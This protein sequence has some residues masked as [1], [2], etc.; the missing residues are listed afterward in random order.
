M[1]KNF[2]D[3]LDE[4]YKNE[5]KSHNFSES[6]IKPTLPTNNVN[7]VIIPTQAINNNINHE[8]TT[9]QYNQ[10]IYYYVFIFIILFVLTITLFLI[11]FFFIKKKNNI[12]N[13]NQ[14]LPDLNNNNLNDKIDQT[15][16]KKHIS[17]SFTNI[18]VVKESIRPKSEYLNN[19][20]IVKE[21]LRPK[22]EYLEKN[23][24]IIKKPSP[25][26]ELE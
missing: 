1:P 11:L 20:N 22:S 26:F 24:K 4:L 19:L 10:Y 8:S 12:N 23:D 21:P 15:K 2:K 6:F 14:K 25:T 3:F 5:N 18:N 13:N 17:N 16:Q 9:T 7:V